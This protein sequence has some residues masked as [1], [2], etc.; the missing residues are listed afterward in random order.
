MQHVVEEAN[1][2]IYADGLRLG[3]LRGVLERRVID[4]VELGDIA[5]VEV[6]SELDL[7]FV[8]VA[9]EDGGADARGGGHGGRC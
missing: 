1:A 5:A 2:G 3:R 7:G 6:E 9:V 8:G 4:A